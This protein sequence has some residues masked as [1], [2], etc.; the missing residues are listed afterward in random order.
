MRDLLEKLDANEVFIIEV[1]DRMGE[2]GRISF[3]RGFSVPD[4]VFIPEGCKI[5][6]V[7]T[8]DNKIYRFKYTST[9]PPPP[10]DVLGVV[11]V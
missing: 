7:R 4:M 8:D 5:S 9:E 3:L 10:E 6:A 11:R 2:K 1:E